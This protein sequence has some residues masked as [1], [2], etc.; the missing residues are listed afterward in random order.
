[1]KST[2][3]NTLTTVGFVIILTTST[4][5]A[6]P[7]ENTIPIIGLRIN[8]TVE[9][10]VF[11]GIRTEQLCDLMWRHIQG[12]HGWEWAADSTFQ[13][14]M[15]NCDATEMLFVYSPNNIEQYQKLW[16]EPAK[17]LWFRNTDYAFTSNSAYAQSS[18]SFDSIINIACADTMLYDETIGV[19][20]AVNDVANIMKDFDSLWFYYICDEGPAV[21]R[22]R[23]LNSEH[24]YDNF[25]PNIYTQAWTAS[26][27]SVPALNEVENTGLYSWIKYTAE[28]DTVL[29][30]PTTLNFSLLHTI[31]MSEYTGLIE[32]DIG[33]TFTRQAV[34]VRAICTAKYQAPP[35]GGIPPGPVDN[36]PEFICFDWYPFRYVDSDSSSTATMCDNDWVFLIDHFEEGIDS[37]VIPA[38]EY[39][40]PTYYFPQAFGAVSGPKLFTGTTIHY[41]SLLWRKPAPQEFLMS[42]NLALMHQAKGIFPY[43]LRSYIENP[44]DLTQTTNFISSA[45]LDIN[46]IP[47][48][49]PYEEYVY[50]ER[51]P[52]DYSNYAYLSPEELP[53]WKDGFDPLY[54]L[55]DP[56]TESSYPKYLEDYNNWLFKPYGDLFKKLERN[57]AQIV[58][59][60]PEMYDLF[61]CDG[62]PDSANVSTTLSPLPTLFVSP[63]IKVFEN[64]AQD[65]VYLFYVNRYCRAAATPL[66]ISF[67]SDS[68]PGFATCTNRLLDHSRRFIM[69]GT[70]SPS[71]TFTFIDTLGPGE[72]RLVELISTASTILADVRIT[73]N[74][75]W[76]ILPAKGDTAT[77]EMT[78]TPGEDVEILARFYNMGTG[79]KMR[80]QVG[81]YDTSGSS[82]D[83]ID[84]AEI[85][86]YGLPYDSTTCRESEYVEVC[87]EW[88]PDVN[89]I[90]PHMLEA[91]AESW[92]NEPDTSDNTARVTFLVEPNDW[93]TEVRG[94][95]W[96]MT[97][98]SPPI[99]P[100]NTCDI[101]SMYGWTVYTDSISGMFEGAVS[102]SHLSDN[103]MTLDLNG[104]MIDGDEYNYL[105]IALK[106]EL[107]CDLRVGWTD[108]N[109]G[110][111]SIVITDLEEGEWVR[112]E[113]NALADEWEGL[114]ITE[115]WLGFRKTGNL[116]MPVRVGW[117]KL[118]N[119]AL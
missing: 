45:L 104:E 79:G 49:A 43:S 64:P 58:R 51:W 112:I 101:S 105:R 70:E 67:S 9:S 83:T 20:E 4:F 5:A 7:E 111:G 107:Y 55:P 30:V 25:I 56:P 8:N 57:L 38:L 52:K 53:P 76:T 47:F 13:A 36:E 85:N 62:F 26:I 86:F 28:H 31:L 35:G 24:P 84:T 29:A 93:A 81:L 75:V 119:G 50:T 97:A 10:P 34:S 15:D 44:S 87:F 12:T 40:I 90:G 108:S 95:P 33:G 19:Y 65:K 98:T 100:W 99:P 117:V 11:G 118:E 42:C 16:G 114:D 113:S 92:T 78:A 68:L 59:I 22:K 69:D 115:L 18:T 61:W 82:E 21:Q 63:R 27:P 3:L 32:N 2:L 37:T 88:E 80:V 6:E 1:M 17:R 109:S 60:G 41:P 102:S 91:R 77:I 48:N 54:N 110:E 73:D 46:L 72:A 23:M 103:R 96:D 116:Q 39:D 71:G 66:E 14:F 106:A 74:D 89:D 94:D